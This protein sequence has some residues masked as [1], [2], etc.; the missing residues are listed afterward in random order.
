M[1]SFVAW[2]GFKYFAWQKK[3]ITPFTVPPLSVL[4]ISTYNTYT[5]HPTY[6]TQF[7]IAART[8]AA[9]L[10]FLKGG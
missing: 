5:H 2:A 1:I 3:G 6:N 4:Y 8:C 10:K 9:L 7:R